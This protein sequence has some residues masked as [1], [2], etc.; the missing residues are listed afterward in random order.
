MPRRVFDWVESAGTSMRVEPNVLATKFG[1]GYEQAAPDGI[2]DQRE[3]WTYQAA[4][5]ESV[6]AD[7]IEAFLRDGMG[8]RRFDWTPPRRQSPLVFKCVAFSRSMSST[9][10][11]ESITATF[12]QV[13]EP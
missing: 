4:A 10:N 1:D 3:V 2:H 5:V 9:P 13:W 7:Q 8:W 12:E 6:V 11:E